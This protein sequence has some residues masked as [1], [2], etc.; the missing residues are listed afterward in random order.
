[1]QILVVFCHPADESFQR[2]ILEALE[3]RLAADGHAV[4]VLDLYREGFDPVLDAEAWRAHR[5]ERGAGRTELEPHIAALR[6][7]EGLVFVYPTWWFGLPA[8]LKG[9][10]D[11]VWQPG[12]AFSMTNGVFQIHHLTNITRFAAITTYGSPRWVIEG[13]AGDPARRQLMRGLKLQFARGARS[14]WAP[15]Y[16]VD[17]RSP[18]ELARARS[19]AVDRAAGLFRPR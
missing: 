14:A 13:V 18:E 12:V 15:I 5:Q 4:R 9:W 3:A 8:M 10:L 16:D 17:S 2:T 6:E 7:A 11:R 1:M 19:A